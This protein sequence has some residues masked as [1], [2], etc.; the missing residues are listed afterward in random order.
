MR[1][2]GYPSSE[3][4]RDERE[5]AKV[6]PDGLL[7]IMGA[8]QDANGAEERRQLTVDLVVCAL[9]TDSRYAQECV[10]K[11]L[12]WLRD[13]G[14]YVVP[15]SMEREYELTRV[16][17]AFEVAQR[18]D[19]TRFRHLHQMHQKNSNAEVERFRQRPGR[20]WT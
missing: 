8:I 1:Q 4:E 2:I 3:I 20:M 14:W 10:K 17:A 7:Y 9:R 19:R 15:E 16:D 6:G 18:R 11:G 5:A 12:Q 13:S